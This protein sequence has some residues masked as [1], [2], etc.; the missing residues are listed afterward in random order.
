MSPARPFLATAG[1]LLLLWPAVLGL[2]WILLSQVN[3]LYPLDYR[4][5]DI[6]ATINQ[7]TPQNRYGKQSFVETDLA[8]RERL[9]AAITRA[10]NQHGEGLAELQYHTPQGKTLGVFLTPAEVQHLTDVASV[11]HIGKTTSWIA[12]ALWLLGIGWLATRRATMPRLRDAAL[13]TVILLATAGVIVFVV[14]PIRVFDWFHRSVFPANH[15]W[16][17]YYQ[18]SLM[19]TFMQAPNLFGL[20]VIWWILLAT[21][22]LFGLWFLA[23]QALNWRGRLGSRA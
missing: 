13:G 23:E 11:V 14:G 7:Y 18:D 20:I 2:A 6:G 9:F 21:A 22:L 3:F 19:T 15:A 5:L 8:E 4:L 1:H 16:F 12:L 10:I 17:F